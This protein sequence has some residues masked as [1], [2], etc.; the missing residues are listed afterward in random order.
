MTQFP[1]GGN[2]RAFM[3]EKLSGVRADPYKIDEG[4]SEGTRSQ[5]G[6]DSPMRLDGN[7][8]SSLDTRLPPGLSL[9]DAVLGLSEAE[10]KGRC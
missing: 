10:R 3:F 4:Y 5:E 7:E 2:D 6:L 8:D 9:Q 1:N